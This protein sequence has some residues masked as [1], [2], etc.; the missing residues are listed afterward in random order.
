VALLYSHINSP[1]LQYVA[2]LIFKELLGTKI[3]IVTDA[4]Y[5]NNYDGVKINYSN[6]SFD[7]VFSVQPHALLFEN[8]IQQQPI[9][10]FE[11]NGT[12]AFFKTDKGDHP[13][14]IFAATFY[15][16][17][18]YEEYLPYE[19][20]AY[21]RY[22]HTN[23]LAFKQNF[24]SLPLVNIWVNELAET[25]K[26]KF[27][28][29]SFQFPAFSFQPTYDIDMAFSYKHKGVIRNAGGFLRSP[30]WER[31]AVLLGAKKD[32]FDSYEWMDKLHE[33]NKL[34][35]VYFFLVAA[36][37]GKYDKNILLHK[38]IMH[39]LTKR[40]A[41]KYSTGLH[42]SWQSGDDPALLQKEKEHLEIMSGITITRSRQHYIRFELPGTYERL[43]AAGITADYSMGYGT[44]NGF[45]AS[46]ASPFY[47]YNL[48]KDEQT[49]LRIYPFCFMDAN[50][51][52]EERLSAEAAYEE[53]MH[54]Y[55]ICKKVNGTLITIW[56]N[57]FL[58]SSATFEGWR[59]IYERFIVQLQQ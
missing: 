28:L 23:S 10:C 21:G 15:L 36:K 29:F 9:E 52:Y 22:S 31:I 40:Y 33:E 57:N 51:F 47:W 3:S 11:L 35:P 26:Y 4:V 45:R 32:P 12:T 58:G 43:L 19:K 56:H 1:R 5:F 49:L 20:D 2:N 46:V 24:L 7:G 53:L 44:I 14:D 27:P 59:A 48:Q 38:N 34:Q 17:S 6:E 41:E 25:L 54:Y 13:F 30:S 8:S 42:P 39:R 55:T 18:R 37:N 50:S 16:I